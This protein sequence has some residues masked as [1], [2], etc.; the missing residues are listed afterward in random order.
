MKRC[1]QFLLTIIAVLLAISLCGCII[2]PLTKYYDIPSEEVASVQFYDLRSQDD[3][4]MPGF[5]DKIDPIYTLPEDD[6]EAGIYGDWV[7]RINFTSGQYTFYSCG[8]FG[9][10]MDASGNSIS[11]TH[12]YCQEDALVELIGKYYEIP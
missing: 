2:I 5:D 3:L 12:F 11:S 4:H 6:V 7:I 1:K 8:G 9:E 10:T